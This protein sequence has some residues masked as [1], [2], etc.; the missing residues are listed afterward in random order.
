MKPDAAFF[1]VDLSAKDAQRS[2]GAARLAS[3]MTVTT[4]LCVHSF[5]ARFYS[6][7]LLSRQGG[8]FEE[9][10][11]QRDTYSKDQHLS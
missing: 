5:E 6:I 8:R 3:T 9:E 4:I 10:E 11:S 1:A 7:L 2:F